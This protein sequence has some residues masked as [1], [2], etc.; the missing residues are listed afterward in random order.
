MTEIKFNKIQKGHTGKINERKLLQKVTYFWSINYYVYI[1][2]VHTINYQITNSSL[3]YPYN[4]LA[5]NQIQ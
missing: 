3:F 2:K 4:N 5:L 1:S